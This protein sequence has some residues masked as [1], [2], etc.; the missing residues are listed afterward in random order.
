[1]EDPKLARVDPGPDSVVNPADQVKA[2]AVA[3]VYSADPVAALVHTEVDHPA[4]DSGDPVAG[5]SITPPVAAEAVV[6]KIQTQPG[7]PCI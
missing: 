2:S 3:F 5:E 7:R 4:G 6:S 1:M